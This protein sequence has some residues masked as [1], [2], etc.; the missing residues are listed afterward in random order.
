MGIRSGGNYD[1]ERWDVV[2]IFWTY[3]D[4]N[5]FA[6]YDPRTSVGLTVLIEVSARSAHGR[7][8][9]MRCPANTVLQIGQALLKERQSRQT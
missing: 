9:N 5:Y 3:Q 6:V 7:Q 1:A 4:H 2:E 8:R